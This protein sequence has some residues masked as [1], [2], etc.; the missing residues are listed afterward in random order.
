MAIEVIKS[1]AY[2]R[3]SGQYEYFS[4]LE[5]SESKLLFFASVPS[6]D[7]MAQT[8]PGFSAGVLRALAFLKLLC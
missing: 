6:A 1:K 2:N 8:R 3:A 7:E 5:K 4:R